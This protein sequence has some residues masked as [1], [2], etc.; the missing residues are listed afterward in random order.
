MC[1]LSVYLKPIKFILP[2]EHASWLS[3]DILEFYWF[4]YN[5]LLGFV[6]AWLTRLAYYA[7]IV[8]L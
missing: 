6:D 1:M 5:G 2:S 3:F 7:C 8:R 4:V